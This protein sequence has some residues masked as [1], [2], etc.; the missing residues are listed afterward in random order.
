MR[1]ARGLRAGQRPTWLWPGVL[2]ETRYRPLAH[3][4]NDR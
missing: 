4:C 3:D 1:K 2:T